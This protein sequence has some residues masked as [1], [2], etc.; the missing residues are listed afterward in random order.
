[1]SKRLIT[2][3]DV[4]AILY[5][6]DKA[7]FEVHEFVRQWARDTYNTADGVW[8]QCWEIASTISV[9]QGRIS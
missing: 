8:R 9:Q 4:A 5:N 7:D 3:S 6:G 1:M 2:L